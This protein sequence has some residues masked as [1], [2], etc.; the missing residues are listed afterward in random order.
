MTV[1]RWVTITS[2]ALLAGACATGRFGPAPSTRVPEGKRTLKNLSVNERDAT[3]RRANVW[4]AIDT[5]SLNLTAGP[6]LPSAQSIREEFT[7]TFVFPERALTG[8]TPKFLCDEQIRDLVRAAMAER[9]DGTVDDWVRVFKRKRD[10]I[11][12]AR[13]A[14]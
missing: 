3:L 8:N 13:C 14:A 5:R 4:Q 7:C 6:L 2:F 1:Y 12:K 10:E 11:V 9:R